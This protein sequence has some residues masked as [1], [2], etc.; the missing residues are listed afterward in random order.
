MWVGGAE[1]KAYI[2]RGVLMGYTVERDGMA[3]LAFFSNLCCFKLRAQVLFKD[4]TQIPSPFLTPSLCLIKY[5][6]PLLMTR[7]SI[8]DGG[9]GEIFKWDVNV[10]NILTHT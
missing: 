4:S 10:T 2:A 7:N 6:F 9:N 1:N 3:Y 5:T 8:R